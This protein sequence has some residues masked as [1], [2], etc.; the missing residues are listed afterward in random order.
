MPVSAIVHE[1]RLQRRFDPRYLGEVDVP[2]KLAF[3]DGF[4]IEL[5]DLVSVDH[6]HASFLGVGG[7]DK[8]LLDH[9]VPLH[10]RN[11]P[12]PER[13]P[14]GRAVGHGWLV[15]ARR[16][17]G[18]MRTGARSALFTA[19][20]C[21]CTRHRGSVQDGA[22]RAIHYVK[23][24]SSRTWRASWWPCGRSFRLW[25]VRT[26]R[27][28]PCLRRRN[29]CAGMRSRRDPRLHDHSGARQRKHNGVFVTADGAPRRAPSVEP[30]RGT[31]RRCAQPAAPFVR[32][33]TRADPPSVRRNPPG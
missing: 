14:G 27:P 9:D 18:H 23:P 24:A 26:L 19:C 6:D 21:V 1:G 16:R 15:R 32:R 11:G 22:C 7:I 31:F 29:S 4:K 30:Q 3:V 10:R 5:L 8:H 13:A 17:A 28:D 2:R 33:R 20:P 12:G 25:H